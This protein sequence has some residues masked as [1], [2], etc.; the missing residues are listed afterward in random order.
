M[1]YCKANNK[2]MAA[3]LFL[4]SSKLVNREEYPPL[5]TL[6]R[7]SYKGLPSAYEAYMDS[8]D[9]YEAAITITGAMKNWRTL[10]NSSW[11]MDGKIEWS[12]EG[13]AIW[14]QDM[15]SRDASDAL[16]LIKQCISEGD[17]QAAKYLYTESRKNK[18]KI[19]AR[20]NT[21]NVD[22]ELTDN[23]RQFRAVK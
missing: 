18:P 19:K 1:I 20:K 12:H 2:F 17:L 9:E 13:I 15:A 23:I 16:K 6:K 7:S 3:Q 21:S 4:E 11:F 8:V 5:W 10:C 22:K 14:R